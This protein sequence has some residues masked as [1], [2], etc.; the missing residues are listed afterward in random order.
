MSFAD[1]VVALERRHVV[2]IGAYSDLAGRPG[3]RL[4]RMLAAEGPDIAARPG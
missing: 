4:S 3:S 1:T 2:E